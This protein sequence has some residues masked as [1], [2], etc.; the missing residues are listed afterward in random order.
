MESR[1]EIQKRMFSDMIIRRALT[2]RTAIDIFG[3]R[4]NWQALIQE[5][6]LVEVR[7]VY[8][9]VLGL[10]GASHDRLGIKDRVTSP[11]T[12]CDRA[13]M[14]DA[15]ISLRKQGYTPLGGEYKQGKKGGGHITRYRMRVPPEQLAIAHRLAGN[16][17]PYAKHLDGTYTEGPGHPWLYAR[18]SGGGIKLPML[19]ELLQRHHHDLDAWWSPL[20]I[21][22][23]AEG[24]IREHLRA[25]DAAERRNV[26]DLRDQQI[27]A[28]HYMPRPNVHLIVQPLPSLITRPSARH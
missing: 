18:C 7:T 8:G 22:V 19:K 21:V 17:K 24:N 15:V 20:I 28:A 13:Y 23:P 27:Y 10:S 26:D 1:S 12:L 11:S 5:R 16:R 9:A 6:H 25:I 2:I 4:P 14:N 3:P